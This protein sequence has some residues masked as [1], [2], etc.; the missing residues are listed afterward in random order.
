MAHRHRSTGTPSIHTH[1]PD[2]KIVWVSPDVLKDA[3]YNPRI[4]NEAQ[5]ARLTE[6]ID[7]FGAV[8]PLVVNDAK[9][10]FNI[11]IGGHFRLKVFRKLGYKKVPI[12]YVNIPSI[13]REKELIP[14]C[15][16]N[17]TNIA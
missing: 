6:S 15:N 2:L 4:H 5:E 3:A 7:D 9:N 13:E 11:V 10:R 17:I 1:P 12:V 16:Q 8:E 14:T